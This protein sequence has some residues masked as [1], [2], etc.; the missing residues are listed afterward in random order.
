MDKWKPLLIAL[1]NQIAS[2]ELSKAV[3]EDKFDGE[4]APSE[5]GLADAIKQ[6]KELLTVDAAVNNPEII[7]RVKK[8]VYP[9]HMKT[10]LSKFEDKLKPIYDKTGI[11]YSDAEF[12]SDKIGDLE[13]ALE[14]ALTKGDSK[15]VIDSLKNDLRTAHEQLEAAAAKS[16]EEIQAVREEYKQKELYNAYVRNAT[17]KQWASH[18]TDPDLQDAVLRKKWDKLTATAHLELDDTGNI[19]VMQK[20]MP[21]KELYNGN[22][23]VT[24]QSLLEPE[25]ESY[26]K[27]SSPEKVNKSEVKKD[28]EVDES[29]R[30]LVE[31]RKRFAMSGS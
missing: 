21:E 30:A 14:T 31:H 23:V 7:D 10:I 24:F 5:E 20:D 12:L 19:K 16:E 4:F 1:S 11:D 17:S 2:D 3:K 15:D 8:D 9:V 22:K 28:E 6:S 18:F 13:T 29:K 26:W 27:K 25:L